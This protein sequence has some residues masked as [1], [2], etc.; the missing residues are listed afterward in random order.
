MALLP[1]LFIC[2]VLVTVLMHILASKQMNKT[3][4][5]K[6]SQLELS[7][8]HKRFYLG[9]TH[10]WLKRS[11]MNWLS[12]L[13]SISILVFPR[14]L[15]INWT[16]NA[17]GNSK[18]W[19]EPLDVI[20]HH[21]C[22]KRLNHFS[23]DFPSVNNDSDLEEQKKFV[24]RKLVEKRQQNAIENMIFAF[25]GRPRRCKFGGELWKKIFHA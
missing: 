6:E 13:Q 18:W 2:L 21:C 22:W 7:R 9:M 19:A 24:Q 8:G 14:S 1:S 25:I 23:S 17:N 11:K 12:D 16:Q 3:R 10:Q 20:I 4:L 15:K 5:W